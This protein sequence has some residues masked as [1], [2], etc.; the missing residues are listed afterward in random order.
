MSK[1]DLANTFSQVPAQ[2]K[3]DRRISGDAKILYA[4]IA[5]ICKFEGAC[6]ATDKKFAEV[7][8]VSERTIVYWLKSLENAGYITRSNEVN[9]ETGR[10]ERKIVAASLELYEKQSEREQELRDTPQDVADSTAK[11]CGPFID[12]I[13][14]I[15]TSDSSNSIYSYEKIHEQKSNVKRN[16]RNNYQQRQ[17]SSDFDQLL[18]AKMCGGGSG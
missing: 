17:Y 16:F 5:Y 7:Y 12:T 2:L 15:N 8:G 18:L 1:I 4:D 9:S 13:N 11:N 14:N 6:Y 3:K 10:K